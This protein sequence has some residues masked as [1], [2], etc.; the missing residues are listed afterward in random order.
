MS[1]P[2]PKYSFQ[3]SVNP[4]QVYKIV[5]FQGDFLDARLAYN[6]VGVLTS[7]TSY[8]S[9][10][11]IWGFLELRCRGIRLGARIQPAI[12]LIFYLWYHCSRCCV[13]TWLLPAQWVLISFFT[14]VYRS[15]LPLSKLQNPQQYAYRF[16]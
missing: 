4:D 10:S 8:Q 12:R 2:D 9:L 15:S 5:V 13:C 16:I 7:L 6:R 14:P 11:Y 3:G 1:P